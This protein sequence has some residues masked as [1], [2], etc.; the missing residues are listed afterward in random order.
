MSILISNSWNRPVCGALRWGSGRWTS[1]VS[2]PRLDCA[3]GSRKVGDAW[4]EDLH[5]RDSRPGGTET[6]ET[7]KKGERN[8]SHEDSV[9]SLP[10]RPGCAAAGA[11]R[12]WRWGC[13]Q[14]A[15][16]AADGGP[17]MPRSEAA[18]QAQ[19][20]W[21][22]PCFCPGCGTC[23]PCAGIRLET[24]G[25]QERRGHVKT[26]SNSMASECR[27]W[28]LAPLRKFLW[29]SRIWTTSWNQA[30]CV[31]GD[32][33]CM[34]KR[35]TPPS[36]PLEVSTRQPGCSS[37]GSSTP[38]QLTWGDAGHFQQQRDNASAGAKG[39]A[40][41]SPWCCFWRCTLAGG[42][43]S[44][45][46]WARWK[47]P[48]AQRGTPSSLWLWTGRRCPA[49]WRRRCP[50]GAAFPARWSYPGTAGRNSREWEFLYFNQD[51]KK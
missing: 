31:S 14:T 29:V 39:G 50:A 48:A 13:C 17:W 33:A 51:F 30:C 36:V 45:C 9:G 25:L 11:T 15:G 34:T 32:A 41:G 27:C 38:K 37:E 46:R 26:P 23:S 49:H 28:V 22:T 24:G 3:A 4:I 16:W 2:D 7:R 8:Q 6:L 44:S 20:R 21:E 19:R 18:G 12:A 35:T 1:H 43:L 47:W 40:W 5:C 10:R 42:D